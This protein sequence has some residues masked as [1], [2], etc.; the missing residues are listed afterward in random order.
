LP[1]GVISPADR[2][3][4][5]NRVGEIGVGRSD[6][7][8][9]TELGK[10]LLGWSRKLMEEQGEANAEGEG[11]VL[12]LSY[13]SFY[14][15]SSRL[16]KGRNYWEENFTIATNNMKYFDGTLT[17]QVK[18]LYNKNFSQAVVVHAFNPSTWEAEA[19]GFL[20]LR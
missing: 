8:R 17:K 3:G 10:V 6:Y 18:G 13:G 2:V 5:G 14:D 9:D 15:Q 11:V 20:S 19:G 4:V 12:L 16:K 7:L 1:Y